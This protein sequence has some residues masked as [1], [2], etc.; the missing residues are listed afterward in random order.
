MLMEEWWS[1]GEG[2][3][4]TR[5]HRSN[6][7]TDLLGGVRAQTS[8]EGCWPDLLGGAGVDA[9]GRVVAGGVG[10]ARVGDGKEEQG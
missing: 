10:C 4:R 9:D 3:D 8:W 6:K 5:V 2:C 1:E 7:G